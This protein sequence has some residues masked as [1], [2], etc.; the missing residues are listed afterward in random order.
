MGEKPGICLVEAYPVVLRGL[1][2]DQLAT[3]LNE[4][5]LLLQFRQ[6]TQLRA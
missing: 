6:H 1:S 2:G 3:D 5:F 4:V